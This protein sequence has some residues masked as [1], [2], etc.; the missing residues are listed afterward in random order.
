MTRRDEVPAEALFLEY[1]TQARRT[2]TVEVFPRPRGRTYV[3]A[4]GSTA[5]LPV[6]PADVHPEPGVLDQIQ[7]VALRV[8]PLLQP[9]R[10]VARQACYRP[11]AQD[12]LPLIG[13]L[14]PMANVYVATGH[15]VWGILNAP[16]TGEAVAELIA[17]G[18]S[19][20]TDLTAFDPVRL[21]ALDPA[22]LRIE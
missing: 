20:S 17:E 15:N 14:A 3:T 6:N 22:S 5:P 9:S 11:I 21:P 18:A 4:F 12:G 10:I 16:A 2:V 7:D 19:D 13:R 1:T 8:S